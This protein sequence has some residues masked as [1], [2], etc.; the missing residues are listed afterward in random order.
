MKT[1]WHANPE[2]RSTI[3]CAM[4]EVWKGRN[5]AVRRQTPKRMPQEERW[6]WDR[7]ESERRDQLTVL[8]RIWHAVKENT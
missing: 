8:R 4:L 3:V 5:E 2:P 1:S 6:M 7:V